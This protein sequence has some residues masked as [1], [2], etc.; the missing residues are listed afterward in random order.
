MGSQGLTD[1]TRSNTT[2]HDR[3]PRVTQP[4][5][6]RRKGT[7]SAE[8]GTLLCTASEEGGIETV[9][10]LFDRGTNVNQTD[11]GHRTPVFVP[12]PDFTTYMLWEG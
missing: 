2:S 7:N 12:V 3:F 1:V 4:S 8:K 9:R 6:D 11:D 10:L 5:I